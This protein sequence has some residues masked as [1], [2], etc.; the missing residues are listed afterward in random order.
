MKPS[1]ASARATAVALVP[2]AGLGTRFHDDGPK[3]LVLLAGKSLLRH[4]LERLHASGSVSEAVVAFTPGYEAAFREAVAPSPFPV[5]LV[6]GGVL[7]RDSVAS[8]LEAS[9]AG[10]EALV[11]VHD[12][13]RPLVDPLEVAAVVDAAAAR[14]AAIAG[15]AMVNTVKRTRNGNVV[16]T[17][18]RH[19]LVS[20]TTPQVFRAGLLRKA[21]AKSPN[22]D[23]TDDAELVERAGGTVAVVLTS[24]W[25]LKITY[26]ED[27]AQAEAYLARAGG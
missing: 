8:A 26:P 16:E 5:R 3:A 12:A 21:Y 11:L 1:P 22:A 20:V 2:A 17:I 6:E 13:A 19:D 9:G 4:T 23:V 24:R 18:P 15:F 25:N 27:L 10:E 7:R 14:G